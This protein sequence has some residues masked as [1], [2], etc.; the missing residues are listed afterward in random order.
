MMSAVKCVPRSE[1]TL[2]AVQI[3]RRCGSLTGK[4]LFLLY[5]WELG[6]T[7][8]TRE[9]A[10]HG[11]EVFVTLALTVAGVLPSLFGGPTRGKSFLSFAVGLVVW[12]CRLKLATHQASFYVFRHVL[13]H[14]RPVCYLLECFIGGLGAVVSCAWCIVGVVSASSPL[15][16]RDY[17]LWR[18]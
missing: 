6:G 9:F 3:L 11:E 8:S 7:L 13:L 16:M 15:A 14:A 10:D 4:L 18:S 5:R 1:L 17:E 2:K 12:V